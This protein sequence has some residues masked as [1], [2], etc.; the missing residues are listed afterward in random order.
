MTGRIVIVFTLDCPGR[1]L[2][3]EFC[4]VAVTCEHFSEQRVAPILF[5]EMKGEA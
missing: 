4:F 3:R 5:C 1:L 2:I